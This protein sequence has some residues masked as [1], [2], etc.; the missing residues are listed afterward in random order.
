MVSLHFGSE[1]VEMR[2][3][4]IPSSSINR[5]A[6]DAFRKKDNHWYAASLSLHDGFIPKDQELSCGWPPGI[7]AAPTS[8][9]TL[10]VLVSFIKAHTRLGQHIYIAPCPRKKRLLAS[11]I[12]WISERDGAYLKISE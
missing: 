6:F 12:P 8:P 5:L 11:G 1:Y 10:H 7:T 3:D 4:P 9:R 2:G